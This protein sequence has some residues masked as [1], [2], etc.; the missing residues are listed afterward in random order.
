V[1]GLFSP[2][3]AVPGAG[4]AVAMHDLD[5]AHAALGKPAGGQKLLAKG[6]A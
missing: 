5:E 3:C 4:G 1:A 2:E 6:L